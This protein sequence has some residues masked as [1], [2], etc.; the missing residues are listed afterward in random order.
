MHIN[1]RTYRTI[2]QELVRLFAIRPSRHQEQHLTTLALFICGIVGSQH[3][4]FA[5]V[6]QHMPIRG[7]KDESLIMRLR[8]W[9]N[10]ADISYDT[11]FLP[12]ARAVVQQLAHMPITIVLDGSTIGRGCMLLMASVIYRK[13][14]IPLIWLV[15]NGRK[16][17]L[18]EHIHCTLIDRLHQLIPFGAVVTVLGDGEFDGVQLQSK[19]RTSGWHYVCRTAPNICITTKGHTFPI[20][21]V[22][23]RRG[24]FIDVDDALFTHKN[25]G[26][27][28][29][30]A[31]WEEPY[32]A[33]IYL[34]TSLDDT[35]EAIR[36]Y[37]SRF[38]IE[39]FFSDQKS[40]GFQ[41][42]KSHLS[43]PDRIARLLIATSLSYLWVLAVGVFAHQQDWIKRFHR[44]D[45][46]D[47]SLFQ[48]GIRA[49]GY[50]VREAQAIP[51][52]FTLAIDG[53]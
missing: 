35:E 41:I 6:V 28:L 5:H 49:I 51:V 4:Q 45:R 2:K 34:V 29:V 24:T 7:R 43:H 15:V 18:A 19:I 25:Y 37:K 1:F 33:P 13:R 8:R 12:V 44:T 38:I 22:K 47:V 21:A 40:R 46:C 27:L 20:G 11:F 53:S 42:H 31:V 32:D 48:C 52:S 23:V 30:I 36:R 39:T 9:L 3:V 10:H 17:H 50:A 16:G 26:P 14:A